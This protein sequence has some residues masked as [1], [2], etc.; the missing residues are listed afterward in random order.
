MAEGFSEGGDF[1]ALGLLV[2]SAVAS[3]S[4][5]GVYF[6]YCLDQFDSEIERDRE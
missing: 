4:L 5:Y 6:L 2:G 1:W 3:G